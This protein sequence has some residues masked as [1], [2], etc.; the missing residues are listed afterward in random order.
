M[1]KAIEERT[2]ALAGVFQ[3]ALLTQQVARRGSSEPEATEASLASIFVLDPPST[4]AVYG[5][6]DGVRRGL[7]CLREQLARGGTRDNELLRYVIALLHLS[8]KLRKRRE[9]LTAIGDGIART[10]RQREHFPL[11][12]TNLIAALAELYTATI[13]TLTPR[14]IVTGEH[15]FLS[16]PEHANQVRALLLSGI[17]SAILWRQNGGS[18]WGVIFGRRGYL[19]AAQRLLGG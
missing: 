5:G 2:L 9:L 3:A 10:E 16:H 8:G 6:L 13:S 18:K 17:R 7:L 1:A 11:T 19:E 12:H 14:I 4:A 15:G